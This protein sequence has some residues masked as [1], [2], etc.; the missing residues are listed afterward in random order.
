MHFRHGGD[1]RVFI[2]SADWMGRSLDRRVELL[3]PI[4]DDRSRDRLMDIMECYFKDHIKGRRLQSGGNYEIPSKRRS[5]GL[6][7]PAQEW[8]YRETCRVAE[9]TSQSRQAVF[10]PH[11]AP[12]Q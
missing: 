12:E 7:M 6:K 2:S 1:D 3:V 5:A 10:E 8:L 4:E 11:R 9:L